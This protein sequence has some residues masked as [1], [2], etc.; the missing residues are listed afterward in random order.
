MPIELIGIV[1]AYL[2]HLHH[3]EVEFS[4]VALLATRVDAI[5]LR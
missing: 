2:D 5:V 4:N 1:S 3:S